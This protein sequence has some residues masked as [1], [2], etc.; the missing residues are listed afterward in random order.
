MLTLK[1]SIGELLLYMMMLLMAV[2]I[3]ASF[4]FYAEQVFE[5]DDN[6]FESILI[7]LWWAV[8]TM[9][10]LGYGMLEFVNDKEYIQLRYDF[11]I[12]RLH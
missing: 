5:V 8:V 7:G 4:V 2:M 9:T 10:T 11:F 6:K 3:F 1:N 12:G